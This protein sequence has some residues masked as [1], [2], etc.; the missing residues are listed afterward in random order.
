MAGKYALAIA[1]WGEDSDTPPVN[2]H[3]EAKLANISALIK[4]QADESLRNGQNLTAKGLAA[5]VHGNELPA[6]LADAFSTS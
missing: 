6:S 3:E 2:H 1:G 5:H 4:A